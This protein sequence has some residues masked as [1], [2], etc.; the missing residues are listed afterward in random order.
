MELFL[1]RLNKF[2]SEGIGANIGSPTIPRI[3]LWLAIVAISALVCVVADPRC[4]IITR[5]K[6]N[7]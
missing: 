1:N 3:T 5:I 4:G 2:Y 7:I 6:R